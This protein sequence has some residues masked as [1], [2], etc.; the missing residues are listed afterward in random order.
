MYLATRPRSVYGEI[1][2]EDSYEFHGQIELQYI[3]P[4][5]DEIR[6]SVSVEDPPVICIPY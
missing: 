3:Q 5:Y 1:C 6:L 2:L 4:L